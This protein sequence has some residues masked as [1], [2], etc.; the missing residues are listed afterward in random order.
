M[1]YTALEEAIQEAER[2][3]HRAKTLAKTQGGVSKVGGSQLVAAVKRSSMDLTR[4][5]AA[6]RKPETWA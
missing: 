3:L 1:T 2:F 6:L 5:L 4:V